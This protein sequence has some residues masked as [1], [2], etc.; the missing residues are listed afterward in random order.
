MAGGFL[1]KAIDLCKKNQ[2]TL[3]IAEL[4]TL[5]SNAVTFT[6]LVLNAECTF[7]L[8]RPTLCRPHIF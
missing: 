1:Q 2:A 6:Q 5:A 8:L 3:L 7:P 4:G